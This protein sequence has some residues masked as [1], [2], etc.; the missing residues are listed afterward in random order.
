MP[1][2]K[3]L[4]ISSV[5]CRWGSYPLGSSRLPGGLVAERYS[6]RVD[7]K[8]PKPDYTV[9]DRYREAREQDVKRAGASAVAQDADKPEDIRDF[10]KL[11]DCCFDGEAGERLEMDWAQLVQLEDG[12]NAVFELLTPKQRRA[13]LQEAGMQL[14]TSQKRS[15]RGAKQEKV[16]FITKLFA[17]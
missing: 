7:G 8:T 15:K 10:D 12:K 9:V 14:A 5:S 16:C 17:T 11:E 6:F 4:W 3:R 1:P 13:I 2:L